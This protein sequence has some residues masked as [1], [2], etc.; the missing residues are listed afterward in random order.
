VNIT[1]DASTDTGGSGVSKYLIWRNETNVANTT[2]LYYN[3]SGLSIGALYNYTVGAIDNAG[4]YGQNSSNLAVTLFNI[5]TN[6]IQ[7]AAPESPQVPGTNVTFSCNYSDA[8]DGSA[9]TDA[10]VYL[11][12]ND[13]NY[14]ATY[15]SSSKNYTYWNNSMPT[16]GNTWYCIASKTS[17]QSQTGASQGYTISVGTTLTTDT[18]SYPN[19][20]AVFYKVNLYD[21][22]SKPTSSSFSLTF[23]YPDSTNATPPLSLYPNNGTGIYTGSYL[24]SSTSP[25]GVWLMKVIE[26]LGATAGKNFYVVA[27]S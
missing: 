20:G 18:N 12:L 19:C 8:A 25:V 2:N 16:G 17:Y 24:L 26:N 14:S 6:L 21:T 5:S 10:T 15:N 22:N 11:N 3:D 23:I 13:V 4:N 9:I 7:G 1:W 27:A